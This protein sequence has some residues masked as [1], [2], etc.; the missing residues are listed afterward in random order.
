MTSSDFWSE[1]L[2]ISSRLLKLITLLTARYANLPEIIAEEHAA[3]RINDL[4][5]LEQTCKKKTE[6]GEQISE[7]FT[8]FMAEAEA[9]FIRAR[10]RFEVPSFEAKGY[11]EVI[12]LFDILVGNSE[13]DSAIAAEVLKRRAQLSEA[14]R[15]FRSKFDLIQP[16]IENNRTVVRTMLEHQQQSFRFW[17]EIVHEESSSYNASGS[18]KSKAGNSMI[19]IQA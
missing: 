7:H 12:Q 15:I 8:E 11:T 1:I 13:P 10:G 6:V 19:N 5:G 2:S 14:F 4:A 3:M 16:M 18:R 9:L 17:A